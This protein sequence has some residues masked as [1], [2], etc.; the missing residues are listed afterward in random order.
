M[1]H[2]GTPLHGRSALVH[3]NCLSRLE[4]YRL[5]SGCCLCFSEGGRRCRFRHAHPGATRGLC[6][7][8]GDLPPPPFYP[9]LQS[10]LLGRA[11]P[12]SSVFSNVQSS[13]KMCCR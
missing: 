7:L 11:P 8:L 12:T 4:Y 10:P 6:S 3:Q 1:V 9:D 13:H 5:E 2:W